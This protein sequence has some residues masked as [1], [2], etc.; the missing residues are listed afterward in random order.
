MM[1]A[2]ALLKIIKEIRLIKNIKNNDLLAI[3]LFKIFK[4]EL[5]HF[6]I[7]FFPVRS[8]NYNVRCQNDFSVSCINTSHFGL[9]SSR[10]FASKA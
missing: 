3:R 8:I 1:I 10:Y 4:D 7:I 2:R 9:N 6:Y 5:F